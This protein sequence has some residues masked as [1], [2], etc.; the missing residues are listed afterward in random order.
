MP[1]TV[2]RSS[3]II[4]CRTLAVMSGATGADVESLCLPMYSSSGV[5]WQV[6]RFKPRT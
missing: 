3:L 5:Y 1:T 4:N 6:V 2:N